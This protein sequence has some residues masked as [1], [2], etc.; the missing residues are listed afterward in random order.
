MIET[1]ADDYIKKQIGYDEDL[2]VLEIEDPKDI[3][4]LE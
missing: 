4:S 3:Y 2:W 1:K